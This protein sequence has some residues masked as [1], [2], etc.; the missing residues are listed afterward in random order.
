MTTFRTAIVLF[1]HLIANTGGATAIEY[2]T[3]TFLISVA[4]GFLLPYLNGEL[5]ALYDSL[6]PKIELITPIPPPGSGGGS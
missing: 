4:I 2:A 3:I 6:V 1:R 5:N